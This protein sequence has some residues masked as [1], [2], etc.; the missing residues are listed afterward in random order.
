M[1]FIFNNISVKSDLIL[2]FPIFW[3]FFTINTEK[4]RERV[5]LKLIKKNHLFG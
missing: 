4:E 1:Y 3:L 2:I 5:S